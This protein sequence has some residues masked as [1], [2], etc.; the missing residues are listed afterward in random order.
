MRVI[1]MFMILM[2]GTDDY[3]F[4]TQK[5]LST[6]VLTP[7]WISKWRLFPYNVCYILDSRQHRRFNVRA[8]SVF[9]IKTISN[10]LLR[11]FKLHVHFTCWIPIWPPRTNSQWPLFMCISCNSLDFNHHKGIKLMEIQMFMLLMIPH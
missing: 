9:M 5:T 7:C 6:L 4:A 8:I 3:K 10:L 1:P 2:T 11:M